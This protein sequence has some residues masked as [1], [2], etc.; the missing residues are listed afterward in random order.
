MTYKIGNYVSWGEA[1]GRIYGVVTCVENGKLWII[2]DNYP[3]G[4]YV[5]AVSDPTLRLEDE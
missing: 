2:P 3:M 1:G 5:V 4:T